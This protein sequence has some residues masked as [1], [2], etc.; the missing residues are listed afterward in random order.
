MPLPPS[1]PPLPRASSHRE[2]V[3]SAS[4]QPSLSSL[5]AALLRSHP[6]S[7]HRNVLN[8]VGSAAAGILMSQLIYWTRRGTDVVERAGWVFKTAEQWQRETGMT[9]KVQQRARRQLRDLGLLEERRVALPCRLEFRLNLNVLA[10]R[11]GE[12]I[13]MR[14]QELSLDLFRSEHQVIKELLGPVVSYHRVLA[15]LV[16][17]VNAALLLSRCLFGMRR[18][19]GTYGPAQWLGLSRDQWREETALSRDEWETARRQ[20]RQRGLLIERQANYPRRVDVMVRCEDLATQIAALSE[21][22]LS[23]GEKALKPASEPHQSYVGRDRAIQGVGKPAP[24][25]NPLLG[26]NGRNREVAFPP[27]VSPIPTQPDP[28]FNDRPIPLSGIDR[29][30]LHRREG[31]Q[32]GLHQ[33]LQHWPDA[34]AE[35][36]QAPVVGVVLS[37]SPNPSQPA[38]AVV[39]A[40]KACLGADL[41]I[42]VA[43]TAAAVRDESIIWPSCI[44]VEDRPVAQRHLAGLPPAQ[45]Q[46]LLDEIAWQD[47]IKPVTHGPSYVRRLRSLVDAGTFIP[48]G[49]HRVILA[50][51]RSAAQALV[52]PPSRPTQAIRPE[53]RPLAGPSAADKTRLAQARQQ[54][55][56]KIGSRWAAA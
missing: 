53:D 11:T 29:S 51:E 31:L 26:G 2:S 12:H 19:D 35:A 18:R 38:A 42:P 33:P 28:A 41:A 6:I 27:P 20:L 1:S 32:E 40:T 25:T 17:H 30:R 54:L 22:K 52:Q 44:A 16:P 14:I 9:W 47:R 55:L 21:R 34:V 50:R 37:T 4:G 8:M 5:N 46:E 36:S 49:A 3:G 56:A 24:R 23:T 13:R 39:P 45:A 43:A 10:R 48:E 15:D 7:V